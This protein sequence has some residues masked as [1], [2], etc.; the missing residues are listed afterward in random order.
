M[1]NRMARC[2][3]AALLAG[4]MAWLVLAPMAKG[5]CNPPPGG[6]ATVTSFTVKDVASGNSLTVSVTTSGDNGKTLYVCEPASGPVKIEMSATGSNLGRVG[7]RA[8]TAS[9]ITLDCDL[10]P[11]GGGLSTAATPNEGSVEMPSPCG[12]TNTAT[13]NPTS[14]RIFY[15]KTFCD[16]EPSCSKSPDEQY[17]C[18]E[19]HNIEIKVVVIRIDIAMDGNR[20]DRVDFGNPEDE[21]YLFW[22]NSDFD[23]KHYDEGMWQQDDQDGDADA[24]DDDIGN[25][26]LFGG[27]SCERDLEDFTRLHLF[28]DDNATSLPGITYHLSWESVVEPDSPIVNIFKAVDDSTKYLS[29]EAVAATQILEKRILT[30]GATPAVLDAVYILPGNRPSPFLLEGRSFGAGDLTFIVKVG[31]EEICKRS[32][33]LQLENMEYFYDVYTVGA[34]GEGWES[35]VDLVPTPRIPPAGYTPA[36]AEKL[37]LIHGWNLNDAE[38]TQ[39]AETTF[40]RLWWQGYQGSV[41]LF[42]WPTLA[43][44]DNFWDV[45]TKPHHFDNSEFRSW[46]SGDALIRVLEELNTGGALRVMAHSLGNA[47]TSEAIRRYA[48]AEHI[49]T[50]IALQA[51]MSAQYYD[52]AVAAAHPVSNVTY[53]PPFYYGLSTPDIFGHYDSGDAATGPYFAGI[54]S[55]VDRMFN[56]FN[57]DDW[58]L[59]LWEQNDVMRPDD[60]AP[61]YFFYVGSETTYEASVDHFQRGVIGTPVATLSLSDQRE[62]YQ[63][64]SYDAESRSVA[65]GQA[66]N[67]KFIG[68]DLQLD[69]DLHFGG[70]HY[71]HSREFRSHLPEQRKFWRKVMTDCMFV[72]TAP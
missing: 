52:W 60:G 46:L 18:D 59:D 4:A 66:E 45:I 20:D 2:S 25:S 49:H 22:V 54:S 9:S 65:L 24:N 62:R 28:V 8:E 34:R 32:V 39:W 21:K 53:A 40:K 58:A 16:V 68:W 55:S 57:V 27:G 69:T 12:G 47:A 1:T 30:L 67:G 42:S 13:L 29:D 63:I 19:G 11:A 41:A 71:S 7:W 33:H 31:G 37:L 64:F 10:T 6:E 23:N 15:V 72:S 50:Y 70:N 48:G 17:F 44:N 51:A 5:A 14:S 61:L 36:T 35:T 26:T 38:K 43:E 56:Y 3:G